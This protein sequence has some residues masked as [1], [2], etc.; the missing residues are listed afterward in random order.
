MTTLKNY[1]NGEFV[2]SKS[3]KY[4]EYMNPALDEPLGKIPIST[5]EEVGLT[6]KIAKDA[7]LKWRKIPG[8]QR[9]QPLLR[10]HGLIKDNIHEIAE[11]IVINHGKE[12]NAAVGE[13]I[14]TYQMIETS[15][16]VP[17][18]QK[19]QYMPNIA[20]GID[21]YSILEPMGVFIMIP[22][23]I[24]PLWSHSGFGHLR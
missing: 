3:S 14:R 17:E 18:Y 7:F 12:W 15:F 16:A 20:T 5:K 22:P 19:G 24:S 6:V 8:I 10:L 23:L 4:I 9:T 2:D 11:S 13:V 21:E 1:I